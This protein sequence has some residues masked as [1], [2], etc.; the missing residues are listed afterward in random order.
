M[1]EDGRG[2]KVSRG[3]PVGRLVGTR[4]GRC[5]LLC[6]SKP[7]HWNRV[8]GLNW[9]GLVVLRANTI[10]QRRRIEQRDRVRERER[11]GKASRVRQFVDRWLMYDAVHRNLILSQAR[12]IETIAILKIVISTCTLPRI[13]NLRVLFDPIS[14]NEYIIERRLKKEN[15]IEE[16]ER[17]YVP[18][19]VYCT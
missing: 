14:K 7:D 13:L 8:I 12:K 6:S 18:L 11:E 19:E 3:R 9:L 15:E 1:K 17:R 5:Y 2:G 4:G 10:R 16:R